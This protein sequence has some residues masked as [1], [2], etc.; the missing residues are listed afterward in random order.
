VVVVCVWLLWFD[1]SSSFFPCCGQLSLVVVVGVFVV[2]IG[3][4]WLWLCVC[5]RID[6]LSL[7]R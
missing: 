4:L 3:G 6:L 5:D 7:D 1:F 2:V